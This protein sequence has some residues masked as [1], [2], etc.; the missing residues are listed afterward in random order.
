MG[1]DTL[2]CTS[3]FENYCSKWIEQVKPIVAMST[4]R[5]IKDNVFTLFGGEE[6]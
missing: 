5:E 3:V 6:G 1:I 4:G 2:F